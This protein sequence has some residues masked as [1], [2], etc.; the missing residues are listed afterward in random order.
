MGSTQNGTFATYYF[1][2]YLRPY[3]IGSGLTTAL[4]HFICD[5]TNRGPIAMCRRARQPSTAARQN[6][7]KIPAESS[8]CAVAVWILASAAVWPIGI[9]LWWLRTMG[10]LMSNAGLLVRQKLFSSAVRDAP[11]MIGAQVAASAGR[12]PPIQ[13][14]EIA[15]VRTE[16]QTWDATVETAAPIVFIMFPGNPGC[17][18]FYRLVPGSKNCPPLF[19]LSDKCDCHRGM[20]LQCPANRSGTEIIRR[21]E[22]EQTRPHTRH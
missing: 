10:R 4:F 3:Q 14:A 15:G 11:S 17:V 18:D 13:V 21:G 5:C 1:S 6:A 12:H 16:T 9:A 2:I 22:F 7:P 8:A 20:Q 19:R